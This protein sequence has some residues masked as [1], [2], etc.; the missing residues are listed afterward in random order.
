MTIRWSRIKIFKENIMSDTKETMTAFRARMN[1]SRRELADLAGV[2]QSQVWRMEHDYPV[3][4]PAQAS[5]AD[6]GGV[7][8]LWVKIWDALV[9][10][11]GENPNGKP[12]AAKATKKTTQPTDADAD[13]VKDL[14]ELRLACELAMSIL[15]AKKQS[16]AAI[17]PLH[18]R[19]TE[20]LAGYEK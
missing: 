14:E 5:V 3:F 1:L 13:H 11:E 7:A 8:V 17:K 20:M 6:N 18:D 12:K 2:T 15:K 19:I 16:S 10:F 9:G 4:T